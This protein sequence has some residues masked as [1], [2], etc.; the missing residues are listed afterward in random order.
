[1]HFVTTFLPG[2][3]MQA[4]LSSVQFSSVR[5]TLKTYVLRGSGVGLGEEVGLQ[6][7]SKPMPSC[8]V[9]LSVPLSVRPSVTFVNSTKTSNHTCICIFFSPSGSQT[10]QYSDGDPPTGASNAGGVGDSGP[11][12]GFIACCQRCDRLARC[13]QHGAAGQWQVVTPRRSLLWRD[14]D[15]R[16]FMTRSLN[17]TPKTTFS[18]TVRSDKS[19]AYNKRLC[20]TFCTYY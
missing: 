12:F 17:V 7:P 4:W 1:M 13:Y 19:A 9:R 11:L 8:G 16:I 20:S 14:D 15:D 6:P 10:W 3:A 18:P 2:D 5:Y